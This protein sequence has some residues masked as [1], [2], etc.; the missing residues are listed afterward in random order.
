MGQQVDLIGLILR[1]T[2]ERDFD[3][4]IPVKVDMVAEELFAVDAVKIPAFVEGAGDGGQEA[5][6]REVINALRQVIGGNAAVVMIDQ[7]EFQREELQGQGFG[8]CVTHPPEMI[9]VFIG[10]IGLVP[11]KGVQPTGEQFKLHLDEPV[12]GGVSDPAGTVFETFS[13]QGSCN[14]PYRYEWM[15]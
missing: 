12:Q 15:I 7:G 11:V 8:E 14:H 10:R 5:Q 1:Q 6:L 13:N 2:V 9:R 3:Q 4:E